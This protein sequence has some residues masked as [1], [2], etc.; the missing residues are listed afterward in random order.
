MTDI[1]RFGPTARRRLRG[2]LLAR[3][4]AMCGRC[5][6]PFGAREPADVGHVVPR[7]RGGTDAPANLRLEHVRC[8][9]AA[10]ADGERARIVMPMPAEVRPRPASLTRVRFFPP[11]RRRRE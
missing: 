9:R 3:D 6:D 10:R 4:G 2:Y 8:N 11:D 1:R 5:G 7:A